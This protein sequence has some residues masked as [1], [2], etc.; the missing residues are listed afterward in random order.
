MEVFG[1]QKIKDMRKIE[2]EMQHS[3]LLN[4]A[5]LKKNSCSTR[6]KLRANLFRDESDLDFLSHHLELNIYRNNL[7]PNK[8]FLIA[9]PKPKFEITMNDIDP[10]SISASNYMF[11]VNN[12]EYIKHIS[13]L[14]LVVLLLTW[15]R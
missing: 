15:S 13:Q 6:A 9:I 8:D 14:V 12:R 10:R 3:R 4:T 11:K 2:N 1:H 5:H 7:Q